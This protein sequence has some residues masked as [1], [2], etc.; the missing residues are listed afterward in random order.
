MEC[1]RH[2]QGE[3]VTGSQQLREGRAGSVSGVSP[4]GS[5]WL[6]SLI[7]LLGVSEGLKGELERAKKLFGGIRKRSRRKSDGGKACKACIGEAL[8][9][10]SYLGPEIKTQN[11]PL[12]ISQSL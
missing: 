7:V 4:L 12:T 9:S 3:R 2:P 5:Y 8:L 6:P 11:C 10:H 1:R